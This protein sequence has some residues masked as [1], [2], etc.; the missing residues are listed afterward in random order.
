MSTKGVSAPFLHPSPLPLN[1]TM[2]YVALLRGMGA[3]RMALR[4]MLL[5]Q[6]TLKW[7]GWE[8]DLQ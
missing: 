5:A 4:G 6:D 3:V 2:A 8:G 1:C 7:V